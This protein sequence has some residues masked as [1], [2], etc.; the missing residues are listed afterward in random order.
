M[1][2]KQSLIN[3]FKA[4]YERHHQ[5]IYENP[6]PGNKAGG[7]TT[8]DDLRALAKMDLYGAVVGRVLYTGDMNVGDALK[9]V[10]NP[11]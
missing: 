2:D 11:G 9:A 5:V 6:S 8:L 3:D 10:R 7:I 1:A 4:Y